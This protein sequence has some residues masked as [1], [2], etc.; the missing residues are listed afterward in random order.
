MRAGRF[1]KQML[2][3]QLLQ[4]R[5]EVS[6][7]FLEKLKK[8]WQQKLINEAEFT[9]I[10]LMYFAW[11]KSPYKWLLAQHAFAPQTLAKTISE[12]LLEILPAGIEKPLSEVGSVPEF[13][14]RYRLRGVPE[15]ARTV[16]QKWL[17]G[18][19]V[20]RALTAEA[21]VTEMLMSQ[22]EGVRLVTLYCDLPT[23]AQGA[24]HGRDVFSFALHDLMHAYEF[25]YLPASR[26]SQKGM[27]RLLLQSHT[28]GVFADIL[29]SPMQE[30]LEYIFS[31]LNAYAIH[32]LRAL[33]GV[34]RKY[35][36]LAGKSSEEF[37]VWTNAL[38]VSWGMNAQLSQLATR[39]SFES[40]LSREDETI[41]LDFFIECG[42]S[43]KIAVGI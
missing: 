25:F 14:E 33:K 27:Y 31:D 20:L 32:M 39:M 38:F 11:L 34:F 1:K 15:N 10:Y 8:I 26:D 43:P 7:E 3:P 6:S 37:H 42:Q 29:R 17:Q 24:L 18:E 16:M 23:V 36:D 2:S 9:G 4:S 30:S 5:A 41:L 40:P 28:A 22:A 13:F 21:D 19:W 12:T 35:F